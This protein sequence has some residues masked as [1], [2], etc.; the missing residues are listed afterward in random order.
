M[1]SKTATPE[2]LRYATPE[3]GEV[4]K[5]GDQDNKKAATRLMSGGFNG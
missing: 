5:G 2:Q 4:P 1:S 3:A